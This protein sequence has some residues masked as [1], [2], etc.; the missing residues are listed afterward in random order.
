MTDIPTSLPVNSEKFLPPASCKH[1][2]KDEAALKLENSD[3]ERMV[4]G[5]GLDIH[6]ELN[7]VSTETGAATPRLRPFNPRMSGPACPPNYTGKYLP[8]KEYVKV[9]SDPIELGRELDKQSPYDDLLYRKRDPRLVSKT[10]V[11]RDYG[12]KIPIDLADTE[13][14]AKAVLNHYPD[15]YVSFL[16]EFVSNLFG[17]SMS[18][19]LEVQQAGL[20]KLLAQTDELNR[21]SWGAY[22][23]VQGGVDPYVNPPAGVTDPTALGSKAKYEKALEGDVTLRW[24][25]DIANA[26]GGLTR[27][28]RAM[29]GHCTSEDVYN[30]RPCIQQH[31]ETLE[32]MRTDFCRGF[33]TKEMHVLA[34]LWYANEQ[35]RKLCHDLL[36][37]EESDTPS[38]EKV[39]MH[40]PVNLFGMVESTDKTTALEPDVNPSIKASLTEDPDQPQ[41]TPT[42]VY[43]VGNWSGNADAINV[44]LK[45]STNAPFQWGWGHACN[46]SMRWMG[47]HD[48]GGEGAHGGGPRPGYPGDMYHNPKFGNFIKDISKLWVDMKH[49][50][51]MEWLSGEL[52]R[53]TSLVHSPRVA[54]LATAGDAA[55]TALQALINALP[56][57]GVHEMPDRINGIRNEERV[58]AA[59]QRRG[60]AGG[61]GAPP[62]PGNL[63]GARYNPIPDFRIYV[64]MML[65]HMKPTDIIGAPNAA[66]QRAY[67]TLVAIGTGRT[68]TDRWKAKKV[69]TQAAFARKYSELTNA[70]V[71]DKERTHFTNEFETLKTKYDPL[72]REMSEY[73]IYRLEALLINTMVEYKLLENANPRFNAVVTAYNRG[74]AEWV[75]LAAGNA[76]AAQQYLDLVDTNDL[77]SEWVFQSTVWETFH[78][79]MSNECGGSVNVDPMVAPNASGEPIY[80]LVAPHLRYS[81]SNC[82]LSVHASQTPGLEYVESERWP[83][84]RR[85]DE[86]L[87][88]TIKRAEPL[89]DA[90]SLRHSLQD[91]E[92]RV[93]GLSFR[94][95][96]DTYG[97]V[98]RHNIEVGATAPP[99]NYPGGVHPGA[100]AIPGVPKFGLF[101]PDEREAFKIPSYTYCADGVQVVNTDFTMDCGSLDPFT[102]GGSLCLKEVDD[103]PFER[104][105]NF[106]I[107]KTLYE[108]QPLLESNQIAATIGCKDIAVKAAAL[109]GKIN[110]RADGLFRDL[111]QVYDTNALKTSPFRFTTAVVGVLPLIAE[112]ADRRLEFKVDYFPAINAVAHK[113]DAVEYLRKFFAD[114]FYTQNMYRSDK[115]VVGH[116]IQDGGGLVGGN[117]E[118]VVGLNG[119]S[120]DCFDL[121]DARFSVPYLPAPNAEVL[122]EL[123][124]V[125]MKV[126]TGM[127]ENMTLDDIF[128]CLSSYDQKAVLEEESRI[129]ITA[130]NPAHA[131]GGSPFETALWETVMNSHWAKT[132]PNSVGPG[133]IS[134]HR[135][136]AWPHFNCNTHQDFRRN[137]QN[138]CLLS[139]R[140]GNARILPRKEQMVMVL[141]RNMVMKW[142]E[143]TDNSLP[144]RECR[145]T[146]L[147]DDKAFQLIMKVSVPSRTFNN[148]LPT[149]STRKWQIRTVLPEGGRGLDDKGAH[150]LPMLTRSNSDDTWAGC[151]PSNM[152]DL[153]KLD[154]SKQKISVDFVNENVDITGHATPIAVQLCV[155]RLI[156]QSTMGMCVAAYLFD[157]PFNFVSDFE[158]RIP[159]LKAHGVKNLVVGGTSYSDRMNTVLSGLRVK[160]W[161][162]HTFTYDAPSKMF[163]VRKGTTNFLGKEEG[164]NLLLGIARTVVIRRLKDLKDK[165]M[166]SIDTRMATFMQDVYNSSKPLD[167]EITQNS[168]MKSVPMDLL[169]QS[170]ISTN[171]L[172]GY[173]DAP[174][175]FK[176]QWDA[177]PGDVTTYLVSPVAYV[178]NAAVRDTFKG[179]IKDIFEKKYA[180]SLGSLQATVPDSYRGV[181]KALFERQ[182]GA[183]REPFDDTDCNRPDY[184]DAGAQLPYL[185]RFDNQRF[186]YPSTGLFRVTPD[187]EWGRFVRGIV[188]R[189]DAFPAPSNPVPEYENRYKLL[190]FTS[191]MDGDKNRFA[192]SDFATAKYNYNLFR[193][194]F[195]AV[196]DATAM[197]WHSRKY[198]NPADANRPKNLQHGQTCDMH[199]WCV[200]LCETFIYAR[201]KFVSIPDNRNKG[202]WEVSVKT[203]PRDALPTS[204]I[205]RMCDDTWKRYFPLLP[206]NHELR[207]ELGKMRAMDYIWGTLPAYSSGAS[208]SAN[209]NGAWM[210][211]SMAHTVRL[212]DTV[213]LF[214]HKY[215]VPRNPWLAHQGQGISRVFNQSYH[216]VYHTDSYR[217]PHFR[218]WLAKACRYQKPEEK[219]FHPFSQYGGTP[220]LADFVPHRVEKP[221]KENEGRHRQLMYNRFGFHS[222]LRLGQQFHDTGLLQD[223][224]SFTY[225]QF[226][227]LSPE[228][229]GM[230]ADAVYPSNFMAYARNHAIIALASCNHGTEQMSVPRTVRNLYRLY[231]DTYVCMGAKPDDD[232]VPCIMGFLPAAIR[233]KEDRPVILYAGSLSCL[234]SKLEAFCASSANSGERV[235][236]NYKQT[237]LNDATVLFNRLLRAER[238]KALHVANFSRA[239]RKRGGNYKFEEFQKDLV[240]L[241][242]AYIEFL[243][244]T[245]IGMLLD[246][247]ADLNGAPLHLLEPREL[248]VS[249]LEEDDNVVGNDFLTPATGQILGS[250]DFNGDT[251]SRSQ[252]AILSLIPPNHRVLGTLRLN[253][254]TS[255]VDLEHVKKQIQRDTISSNKKVWQKYSEA[256]VKAAFGQKLLEVDGPIDFGYDL[257]AVQDPAAVRFNMA[258]IKD[259]LRESEGIANKV[260]T[261]SAQASSSVSQNI[262]SAALRTDRGPESVLGMNAAELEKALAAVSERVERDYQKNG[263]SVP[264]V[265]C[266]A[267]LKI[268][269]HIKRL[270]RPRYE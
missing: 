247:G 163:R 130:A 228:Q 93:P 256:L 218:E 153:S 164:T 32:H 95:V 22:M 244:T 36:L 23:A 29:T 91:E 119:P 205:G 101:P 107:R 148:V 127:C 128:M 13:K 88:K 204:Y 64:E 17:P 7:V 37:M 16:N 117:N 215:H 149:L 71:T 156:V 50:E 169:L 230:K 174:E 125:T 161:V 209:D 79:Q 109:R 12:C 254:S 242:D 96:E 177:M 229:R 5:V 110:A 65:R 192:A 108:C 179:Y 188:S 47:V 170:G 253:Q 250:M 197:L 243:Q 267:L 237:Y 238:R 58:R 48:R 129:I 20:Q 42:L 255:I 160:A 97:N 262:R 133:P 76:V 139:P 239:N 180:P 4:C 176:K 145:M 41:C 184:M 150:S 200:G 72:I 123:D 126:I 39:T 67:D 201:Q 178:V 53:S 18:Q 112:L 134:R 225:R 224:Y 261:T 220:V 59:G 66:I 10:V 68:A 38:Y 269:E 55:G 227:D 199:P 31:I 208:F 168:A 211:L 245:I 28:G 45:T 85:T 155:M 77:R 234:N 34:M 183:S 195:F 249:M 189:D 142:W 51:N 78:A 26:L 84:V 202:L 132:I 83:L 171:V 251:L 181:P 11:I 122:E 198:K 187:V 6:Y 263:G 2:A 207:K 92:T 90:R 140:D 43:P 257:S 115:F 190:H 141:F 33:G 30:L 81:Y 75:G 56:A 231:V 70:D 260:S 147:F 15:Q 113:M 137:D 102:S 175:S 111:H 173:V 213:G 8:E 186:L 131:L 259:P 233:G 63:F 52:Q 1:V 143:S 266:L 264:R 191:I 60:G 118:Y 124:V 40:V 158:A 236:L 46:V 216:S 49:A 268:P 151:L 165:N 138:F 240:E 146:S 44:F 14:I 223:L 3:R 116:N 24:T 246:S 104:V 265:K 144:N 25:D 226:A 210:P 221:S 252:L 194:Q 222:A 136:D 152:V 27:D 100:T 103:V 219:C 203:N 73:T 54:A 248:E 21:V 162:D 86:S 166:Y 214:D 94:G 82:S 98:N 167:R 121:N 235:C 120:P 105:A 89:Q 74:L 212:M 206:L 172:A 57:N 241:Q 69:E 62:N 87:E 61:A 114:G 258:D 19:F 196:I 35:G 159:D 193:P 182:A 232:G 270:L 185:S 9:G 217:A 154:P 135:P 157:N 80:C 99:V 106:D